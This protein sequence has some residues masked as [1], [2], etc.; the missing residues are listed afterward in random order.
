MGEANVVVMDA[1]AA[2]ELFAEIDAL[3]AELAR[4]R[5]VVAQAHA[6]GD[7]ALDEVIG[8]ESDRGHE[9]ARDA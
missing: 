5:A 8:M 4:L 3:R 2:R 1:V 6:M 7:R 9:E